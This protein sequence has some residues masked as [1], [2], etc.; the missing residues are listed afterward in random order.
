MG[1]NAAQISNLRYKNFQHKKSKVLL[2]GQKMS[3]LLVNIAITH[4][5]QILLIKRADFEVWGLPGGRVEA[6]ESVAA[7]AVREAREETGLTIELTHLV[8]IYSTVGDN[9][10][11]NHAVLFAARH[12]SGAL[13]W[14]RSEVIEAGYFSGQALPEPLLWLHRQRIDDALNGVGGSVARLQPLAWPFAEEMSRETLYRL[15]DQ[16]GLSPQDFYRRYFGGRHA[17]EDGPSEVD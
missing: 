3:P 4:D 5:D 7:A 8:G 13:C 10:H 9:G 1:H 16:S 12:S 15:R 6:G 2:W 17:A 11:S 14:P